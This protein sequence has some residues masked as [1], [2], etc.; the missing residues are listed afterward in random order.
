[1][2]DEKAEIVAPSR[3]ILF[4]K[5]CFDITV[6]TIGLIVL[7]PLLSLMALAIWLDS[8][9]TILFRQTR[10]GR[11]G[12]P[13]DII[14]FRTMSHV[15]QKTGLMLTLEGD[16]RITRVGSIM[17][18]SKLDELPQL[19]NVIVG[20]MSLVGPR[21]EV[22]ELFVHYAPAQQATLLA[23]RPGL[24][25][26]AT[27]LLRDEGALLARSGDPLAFY[28]ESLMPLKYRL[29]QRYISELGFW[30]DIRI[31]VATIWSMT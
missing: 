24:T 27:L 20:D 15:P 23:I 31:I 22:P 4:R 5:R 3:G 19:L 26:Y 6:A 28:R 13:F 16:V 14:K 21:P 1:M 10:V 17:R 25:D 2:T 8:P 11:L 7:S 30:T 29:C 12:K 9:G 18:R